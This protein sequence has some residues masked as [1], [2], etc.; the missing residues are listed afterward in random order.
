MRKSRFSFV[1][2]ALL[3]ASLILSLSFFAGCAQDDD[4]GINLP[5]GVSLL[6]D[7]DPI[8]NTFTGNVDAKFA[9]DFAWATSCSCTKVDPNSIVGFDESAYHKMNA[10]DMSS[11]NWEEWDYADFYYK[12]DSEPVYVVYNTFTDADLTDGIQKEEIDKHS[13]VVIFKA[14]DSPWGSPTVGC[15]YGVKFQFLVGEKEVPETRTSTTQYTD[16]LFIEG[17][18]SED[19]AYKNVSTLPEAVLKF[20]FNNTDYFSDTS[21]KYAASGATIKSDAE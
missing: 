5:A 15:Y 21:W 7:S 3:S 2:A 9:S 12:K 4:D 8:A 20:G 18:Y 11:E 19:S 1:R 14:K 6:S 13:G 17:G 16:Y 10:L